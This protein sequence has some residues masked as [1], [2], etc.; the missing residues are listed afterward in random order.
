[1]PLTMPEPRYFSIPSAVVGGAA[2]RNAALNWSPCVRS[3][4]QVPLAWTNSPA[5]IAAAAPTTVARS[6]WPRTLTRSTQKPVSGLWNVTRSTSP[7]SASR[8]GASDA[9]GA[10][11]DK[12][13]R[14]RAVEGGVAVMRCEHG[15]RPG[16]V[17]RGRPPARPRGASGAAPVPRLH[18]HVR[19][20]LLPVVLGPERPPH[21]PALPRHHRLG[22]GRP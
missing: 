9:P 1:M 21:P 7:A 10:A 20:Q 8:P 12:G 6:R 13:E 22:R 5:L 2:L 18:E 16:A 3:L 15:H 17:Q 4:T 19:W 11:P 14:A